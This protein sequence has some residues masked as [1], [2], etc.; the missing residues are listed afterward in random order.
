MVTK[1]MVTE[2][3]PLQYLVLASFVLLLSR[4]ECGTKDIFEDFEHGNYQ[5]FDSHLSRNFLFKNGNVF[6]LQWSLTLVT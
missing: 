3:W 5:F 4:N 2:Y 1:L 6:W